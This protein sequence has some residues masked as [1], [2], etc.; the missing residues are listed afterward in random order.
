MTIK[1]KLKNKKISKQIKSKEDI[2][3][4]IIPSKY[5]QLFNGCWLRYSSNNQ[6]KIDSGGFM[7]NYNLNIVSLKTPRNNLEVHLDC[8]NYT[9]YCNTELAQYQSLLFLISQEKKLELLLKRY[10]HFIIQNNL[11]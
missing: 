10:N 8:S 9:F 4:D 2:N 6:N 3:F 1:I 11:N 5:I 7:Y